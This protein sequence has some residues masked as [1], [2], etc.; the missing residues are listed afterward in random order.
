MFFYELNKLFLDIS[1]SGYLPAKGLST[2]GLLSHDMRL[3]KRI[4]RALSNENE[5]TVLTLGTSLSLQSHEQKHG[6]MSNNNNNSVIIIK[7]DNNSSNNNWEHENNVLQSY[8]TH[9]L[10]Y[11]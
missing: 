11:L 10:L 1:R 6:T 7:C 2:I 4:L 8:C 3:Y 9:Y 5:E